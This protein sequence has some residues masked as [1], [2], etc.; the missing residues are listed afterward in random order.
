LGQFFK[1]GIF[2]EI[3]KTISECQANGRGGEL[4]KK[5]PLGKLPEFAELGGKNHYKTATQGN[6]QYGEEGLGR[7]VK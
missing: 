5:K 6:S 3:A 4:H 1:G 7:S 2:Y